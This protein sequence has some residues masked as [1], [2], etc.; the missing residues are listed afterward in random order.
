MSSNAPKIIDDDVKKAKE[1]LKL[2]E[3]AETDFWAAIGAVRKRIA[4]GE[5]TGDRAL[6]FAFMSSNRHVK[7]D[8]FKPENGKELATLEAEFA[9]HKGEIC[10]LID[11]DRQDPLLVNDGILGRIGRTP[12]KKFYLGLI[13]K[14]E[15]VK[16]HYK[17]DGG[18]LQ[19]PVIKYI[20]LDKPEYGGRKVVEVE[21]SRLN[22][23]SHLGGIRLWVL[24][25][26]HLIIGDDCVQKFV[27]EGRLLNRQ[28]ESYFPKAKELL[29][30]GEVEE[31]GQ[32]VLP[33]G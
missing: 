3:K 28:A 2:Q 21:K 25:E 32:I 15:P 13:S 10:L 33:V 7:A 9:Q 26:K 18:I 14:E 8:F 20:Q 30:I 19:L 27:T 17:S 24:D 31:S 22:V 5:T 4:A 29:T 23:V 16:F 1:Q 12:E 6:D 11:E